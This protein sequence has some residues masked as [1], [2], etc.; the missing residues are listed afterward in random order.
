MCRTYKRLTKTIEFVD[1]ETNY[2]RVSCC[3]YY[4]RS[5]GGLC[6]DCVFLVRTCCQLH[7]RQYAVNK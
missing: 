2:H 4:R 1:Y 6:S 5:D 7:V 3:L